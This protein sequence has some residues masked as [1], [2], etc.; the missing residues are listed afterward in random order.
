VLYHY[1]FEI[2][3][4]IPLQMYSGSLSHITVTGIPMTRLRIMSIRNQ[5]IALILLM[6]ALPMGVIVYTAV[7]QEQHDIEEAVELTVA[8]A[9][10]IQNDQKLMLA[11]A[12]QLATTVSSLPI[13]KQ[14]DAAAVNSLLSEVIT[15]NPQISNIIIVD[16]S[17]TLWASAIPVKETHSFA[18]WRFFKNASESGRISSG[19]YTVGKIVQS[20]IFSFGYPIKDRSGA[21]SDVIAVTVPLER[22]RQLYSRGASPAS[23]SI[24]LVDHRGTILYSSVDPR[25]VGT[26]DRLDLFG[27]MAGGPN[28]G[29]F[30]AVGLSGAKRYFSYQKVWQKGE[31]SPYM[32]IRTGLSEDYVLSQARKGLLFSTGVLLCLML[33]MLGIATWFF[34]RSILSKISAL[35]SVTQKIAGGDLNARV[36]VQVYGGELGE[37]ATSFNEMVQRLLLSDTAR[38]TS[39][40][41]YRELV[42]KANSIILKWDSAGTILYFNEFAESFFG[43]SCDELIGR[44]MIGTIV[45]DTESTGRNLVEMMRSISERPAEFIHVEQEN[46]RKNG[47]R[48][49]ISWNNHPL[50]DQNGRIVGILSVGQDITTRKKVEGEL[51]K[52]EQRFRSFVENVNDVLFAL[53]PTGLF[54]YV[55]PQWK[56]VFGYEIAETIGRPFQLF[57]HSDDVPACVAFMQRLYETGQKQ[58]GVEYRVLSKDGTYLWYKANASLVVDPDSGDATLVGIGRDITELKLA[59]GALRQSEEKFSAAFRASPDAV[60]LAR[61][62]DGI[63]L[64][65]NEGFTAITGYSAEEALGFSSLELNLWVDSGQRDA[66][67]ADIKQYGIAK[68]VETHFRR[69]DGSTI[70][71]HISARVIGI[72]GEQYVVGITRDIT[73][74]AHIQEEL[75][76]AQKLESISILAGG[77]AHN[78]NNV[79]T[80]VIGYI[81]YA[82]KHLED[83]DK[84]RH[85]LDSAEK[86]AYRASGLARQLLSFSRG[87]TPVRE[88]TAVSALVQESVS[89]FLSGTNVK[90]VYDCSE[91]HTIHADSHQINQAFNNIVLNAVQAMPNGG[92]LTVR[93]E[94]VVLKSGNHYRLPPAVYVQIVF[95]DTGQGI[96]R[97]DLGRI[98]DPYFTTSASG[99]GLGLSTT[100]AIIRKH[101]GSIDVQSEQG[102]GTTVRVLLPASDEGV[103]GSAKGCETT[104]TGPVGVSILVIDDEEMICDVVSDI[105]SDLGYD[106][107]TCSSGEE[108]IELFRDKAPDKTHFAVVIMDLVIPGGMGGVDAARQILELAPQTKM[109]ASSGYASDPAIEGYTK[110]GFSGRIVKPYSS[111]EL[112]RVL[113]GVLHNPPCP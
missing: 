41:K 40:S 74:R 90:G 23:P 85:L 89:L 25:L 84:V 18:E 111:D 78:F 15:K 107:T 24:L 101:G 49:W 108:A 106:V 9:S 52:S 97:E 38:S 66:L 35:R 86:S 20:P 98:F 26:Q 94:T 16:R 2:L 50:K 53:T 30:E 73:E 63:Y 55:S 105:L 58:S 29:T 103:P 100:H 7:K 83:V 8:T 72:N 112:S 44:N 80:G 1:Y 22:Y 10:Q 21:V 65:V 93:T 19:E 57:V 110:Y 102:V 43:F 11:G 79:L 64:D 27:R 46:I 13:V 3:F 39:E 75:L 59:E 54:S 36:P 37:L 61:L 5:I 109:I 81:S 67:M 31:Q 91:L 4:T 69:K 104:V 6:T 12:E 87:N 70:L 68:D 88:A 60:T 82:K 34:K 95:E 76:K 71:V 32:Y 62:A 42:E 113:E 48:V 47:E 17:G 33:V 28:E 56:M 51:L 45:P 96:K 99:T 92:T 77:I 14:R